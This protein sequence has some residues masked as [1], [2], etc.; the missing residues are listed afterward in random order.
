RNEAAGA[1]AAPEQPGGSR[2]WFLEIAEAWIGG[3]GLGGVV[4]QPDK[5][6]SHEPARECRG[7]EHPGR[8]AAAA[9]ALA[10]IG[11]QQPG[12]QRGEYLA[13]G[14]VG[15]QADPPGPEQQQH[16]HRGITG[17]GGSTSARQHRFAG[18]DPEQTL[19][20]GRQTFAP[21][22]RQARQGESIMGT[23]KRWILAGLAL[24]TVAAAPPAEV[25]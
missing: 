10:G 17:A 19:R 18:R 14:S 13:V 20:R 9:G 15:L 1:V 5:A 4:E 6:G 16:R 2:S 7:D 25:L 11:V 3:A 8:G 22:L 23:L 12:R 21:A 24:A